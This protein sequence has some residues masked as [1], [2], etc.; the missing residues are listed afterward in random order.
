MCE[1]CDESDDGSIQS[2]Q[3][4]GKLICFDVEGPGDD[5]IGPAGVTSSGDLYCLR[6]ATRHD[7]AEESEEDDYVG[8]PDDVPIE[9]I[10]EDL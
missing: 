3:D 2:C 10:F 4:C 7:E 6:C 9:D 1:L 8:P 5:I